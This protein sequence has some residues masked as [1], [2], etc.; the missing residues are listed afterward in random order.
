M[1]STWQSG[2]GLPAPVREGLERFCHQLENVLGDGL[3]SLVLY[4]GLAKNDPYDPR[5]SDV[6]V[7]VVLKEVTVEILDVL[8]PLVQKGRRAF[9]LSPMVLTENDLRTS[10]DVFPIKFLDMQKH[11]RV[12]WGQDVL[13]E[14]PVAREHLRLRCEQEIKNLMLRLRQFYLQRAHLPEAIEGTLNRALASLWASLA[15]LVELK[16][17]EAPAGHGDVLEAAEKLGLD[18]QALQSALALRRGE[19]KPDAAELKQLY[20]AFMRTVQQAA[21]I[22]DTL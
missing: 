5:T 19:R 16:S 21:E 17:G 22:A 2:S 12:L 10:T 11:H 3:V 7:M 13:A 18:T 4:G 9:R 6:N 15:V 8:A 20:D 14:L 1:E